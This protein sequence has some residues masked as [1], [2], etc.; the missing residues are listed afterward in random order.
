MLKEG[1]AALHRMVH[2]TLKA[3]R[4]RA[5]DATS[6]GDLPNF[7]E[8]YFVLKAREDFTAGEKLSLHWRGPRLF[9][10]ALSYYVFQV[11]YLRT[12]LV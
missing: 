9:V 3:A 4:E 7:V 11:E 12:G 10:Q 8:G 6:R 1:L 5:R 2:Y